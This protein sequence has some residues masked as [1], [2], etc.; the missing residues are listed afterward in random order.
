MNTNPQDNQP[1]HTTNVPAIIVLVLV[2]TGIGIG[3]ISMAQPPADTTAS[4]RSTAEN[5]NQAAATRLADR[6]PAGFPVPPDARVDRTKDTT[7][8]TTQKTL[9]A[10]VTG[11]SLDQ[12]ISDVTNWIETTE[13]AGPKVDTATNITAVLAANESSQLIVVVRPTGGNAHVQ[14]NHSG[15]MDIR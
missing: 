13:M 15:T 10:F 11:Q 9:T 3:A 2:T 5:N 8:T 14:V 7:G 4:V 12:L 6:L 1:D